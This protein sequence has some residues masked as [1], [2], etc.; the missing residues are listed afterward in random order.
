MV[1]LVLPCVATTLLG[2]CTPP[3]PPPAPAPVPQAPTEQQAVAVQA[4]ILKVSP[5][6]VV[7]KVAGVSGSMAAVTD[8]PFATV[9]EPKSILFLDGNSAVVAMGTVSTASDKDSQYLIVE[10]T[11]ATTVGGRAPI[12]GDIAVYI[13][14][15]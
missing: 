8:I 11:P 5:N 3:P 15:K 2:G 1:L 10:Y 14:P 13:P 12:R 4:E 9:K 7:G 6:W